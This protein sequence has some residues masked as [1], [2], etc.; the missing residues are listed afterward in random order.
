MFTKK[1]K[2]KG[3]NIVRV[4]KKVQNMTINKGTQMLCNSSVIEVGFFVQFIMVG[5][6][7]SC[8]SPNQNA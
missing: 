1:E 6:S 4:I 7:F 2:E 8:F 3:K 5:T